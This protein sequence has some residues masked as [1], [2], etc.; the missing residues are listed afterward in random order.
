[1]RLIT[2]VNKD[3]LPALIALNNSILKN[4]PDTPLTCIVD[5]DEE[6]KA[7]IISMGIDAVDAPDFK[8]ELPVS[9]LWPTASMAMYARI[10]IPKMFN[11]PCAWIDADCL[12]LKPLKMVEFSQPVA[13]VMTSTTSI[14]QQVPNVKKDGERPALFSGFL[15]YNIEEWNRLKVT[16][17]CIDA[18]KEPLDFKYA[19]Q[20]LLSYVLKGNFFQLPYH[21]QVFA[22][23]STTNEDEVKKAII[24][25]YV[26]VLP[27]KDK[28]RNLELW[29][30]YANTSN[31]RT[32]IHRNTPSKAPKKKRGRSS[33]L[34]PK[35]NGD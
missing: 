24:L 18:M 8:E 34:R 19:V 31:R 13:A 22:N 21:W 14:I 28:C 10:F 3:Y 5:G 16:G 26:G 12:V 7:E 1:M 9:D 33:N 29:K 15:M 27:W 4:S 17:M 11:E 23:R 20:S 32:G 35:T 2:S 6:F 25:H 30:T